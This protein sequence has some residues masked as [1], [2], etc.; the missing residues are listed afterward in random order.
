ME[1]YARKLIDVVQQ[2]LDVL[3]EEV[4]HG[5]VGVERVA[6]VRVAARPSAKPRDQRIVQCRCG[7][8]T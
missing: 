1:T 6:I 2:N 7:L 4:D 5:I 3:L 8:F